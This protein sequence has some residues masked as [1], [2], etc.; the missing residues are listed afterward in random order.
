MA[1]LL[2]SGRYLF[3]A[4]S[5][6]IVEHLAQVPVEPP[7]NIDIS[8]EIDLAYHVV[9]RGTA[10]VGTQGSLQNPAKRAI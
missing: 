3:A 10:L 9:G 4:I 8:R 2:R 1:L 5:K 6:E 7:R